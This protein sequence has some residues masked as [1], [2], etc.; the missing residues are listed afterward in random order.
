MQR[1][2]GGMGVFVAAST[3]EWLANGE[4]EAAGWRAVGEQLPLVCRRADERLA[5]GC[6][7]EANER[8]TRVRRASK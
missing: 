5:S 8:L 6:W 1:P 4:G 7:Q 3:H 2:R